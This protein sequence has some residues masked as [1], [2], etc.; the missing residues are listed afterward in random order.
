[1]VGG[2]LDGDL[3]IEH[4]GYLAVMGKGIMEGQGLVFFSKKCRVLRRD[5]MLFFFCFCVV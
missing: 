5:M 3:K 2:L 4:L 1:M